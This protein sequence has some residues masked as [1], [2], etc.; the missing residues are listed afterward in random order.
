MVTETRASIKKAVQHFWDRKPCGVKNSTAQP[1]T[2]EFYQEVEQHR[3]RE[4]FHIPLVAEF[5]EHAGERVLEI[6]CGLGTDGRQFVRGEACYIAC[7]L[8]FRSLQLARVGFRLFGLQG[9]FINSDA[10]SLPFSDASFD[11]VYCHGVLHHTPNTACAIGEI[12]RVLRPGGKAIVM[13]YCR[14]SFYWVFGVHL[15]GRLRLELARW[16]LGYQAFNR[17]VGLPLNYRGRLPLSVVISNSTDGLGNPLSKFYTKRQ[18]RALFSTFRE[19]SMQKHY[20]P[21][22]KIP[23][24]GPLIPR[25]VA[26]ALG[27]AMGGLLY[28]K[29]VK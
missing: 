9:A 24:I 21:R 5:A 18:V 8:S 23:I 26:Y 27:K 12:H 29:A 28:V 2:L 16:R 3:Y 14:E 7:E 22:R 11:L 13:F 25:L 10:E 1:G 15:A 19:V 6:G 4:E 17:L 20:F